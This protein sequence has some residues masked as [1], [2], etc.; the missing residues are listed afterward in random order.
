M[1]VGNSNHISVYENIFVNY[2][3]ED[4]TF[5]GLLNHGEPMETPVTTLAYVV[6]LVDK[7]Q[8]VIAN[9]ENAKKV[10]A[11][12]FDVEEQIGTAQELLS[13]QESFFLRIETKEYYPQTPVMLTLRWSPISAILEHGWKPLTL[14]RHGAGT[15]GRRACASGIWEGRPVENTKPYDESGTPEQLFWHVLQKVVE[16][17]E[18]RGLL[19]SVIAKPGWSY[20]SEVVRRLDNL[21][22]D[23]A[24]EADRVIWQRTP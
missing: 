20:E 12:L 18:K 4:Y 15:S 5:W 8:N 17:A 2:K 19:I 14:A 16:Q 23:E 7:P 21:T 9:P 10:L 24:R 13:R 11:Y 6:G 3:I 22:I 1:E